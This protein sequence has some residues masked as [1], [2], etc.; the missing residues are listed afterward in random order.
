ML[1]ENLEFV[2]TDEVLE[3]LIKACKHLELRV[4][5]ASLNVKMHPENLVHITELEEARQQLSIAKQEYL[6][7]S[8]D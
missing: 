7:Y 2:N 4:V 3:F 1:T 5:Q 8:K 6:Q